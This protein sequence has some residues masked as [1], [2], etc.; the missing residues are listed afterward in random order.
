MAEGLGGLGLGSGDKGRWGQLGVEGQED[1]AEIAI[2][3]GGGGD[4]GARPRPS[5]A[6]AGAADGAAAAPDISRWVIVYPCYINSKLSIAEG[7]KLPKAQCCEDP[8]PAAMAQVAAKLGFQ[9][10]I[11]PRKTHPRDFFHPGRIRVRMFDELGAPVVL[12]I[13]DRRALY[14]EVAKL[15]PTV[16]I[17]QPP[18]QRQPAAKSGASGSG[19]AGASSSGKA[20]GKGKGKG[21]KKGK[22]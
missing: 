12:A 18:S 9:A 13:K 20:G 22:R 17:V 15:V 19:S 2:D 8:L 10:A 14:R 6:A 11:E 7:R 16:K 3:G 4:A 1:P 21:K 5:A